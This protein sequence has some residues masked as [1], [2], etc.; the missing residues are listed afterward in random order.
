MLRQLAYHLASRPGKD[1]QDLARRLKEV[2]YAGEVRNGSFRIT[3]VNIMQGQ[4]NTQEFLA[5]ALADISMQPPT[6]ATAGADLEAARSQAQA[7]R[8]RDYQALIQSLSF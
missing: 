1:S 2:A 4:I 8:L 6:A 7:E 5:A 3:D